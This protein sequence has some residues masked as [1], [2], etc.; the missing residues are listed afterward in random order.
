[1]LWFDLKFNFYEGINASLRKTFTFIY[2]FSDEKR[3]KLDLE[4]LLKN[5]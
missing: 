3:S 1:M 4:S 5:K 2:L